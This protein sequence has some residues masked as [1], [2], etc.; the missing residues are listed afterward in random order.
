MVQH[1]CLTYDSLRRFAARFPGLA[2]GLALAVRPAGLAEAG[3]ASPDNARRSAPA[4]VTFRPA[5]G[6][7]ARDDRPGQLAERITHSALRR[8]ARCGQVRGIGAAG[9]GPRRCAIAQEEEGQ[10]AP[11]PAARVPN[12]LAATVRHCLARSRSP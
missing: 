7:L 3:G 2:F 9:S 12:T 6:H 5:I 11:P 10:A 8:G 1:R 4:P